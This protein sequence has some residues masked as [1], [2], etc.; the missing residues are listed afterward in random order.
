MTEVLFSLSASPCGSLKVL[1]QLTY[2]F[3]LDPNILA[4]VS[5][6]VQVVV[7]ALVVRAV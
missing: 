7:V 1:A 5:S 4:I 2:S 6:V 3:K